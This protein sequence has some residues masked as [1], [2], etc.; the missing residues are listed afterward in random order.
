M[1]LF[2]FTGVDQCFSDGP[3]LVAWPEDFVAGWTVGESVLL[4]EVGA[5]DHFFSEVA[6]DVDGMCEVL[7]QDLEWHVVDSAH[8]KVSSAGSS[9]TLSCQ[10]WIPVGSVSNG[11]SPEFF[12][13][14]A[15]DVRSG[16]VQCL[17]CFF[18]SWQLDVQKGSYPSG[19]GFE[20]S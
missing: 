15:G 5:D 13:A 8:F 1:F 18:T 12:F 17:Y 9:E 16:V 14:D 7:V 6:D 20:N 2:F 10:S 3:S 11:Y 4:N 19:L